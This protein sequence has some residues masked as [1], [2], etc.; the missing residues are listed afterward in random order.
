MNEN[1]CIKV[2]EKLNNIDKR[3][4]GHMQTIEHAI[5]KPLHLEIASSSR[6]TMRVSSLVLFLPFFCVFR[7]LFL[8]HLI[9]VIKHSNNLD[10]NN[11]KSC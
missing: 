9:S 7:M 6:I 3:L 1:W 11:K 2:K 5:N 4:F 10:K 8:P